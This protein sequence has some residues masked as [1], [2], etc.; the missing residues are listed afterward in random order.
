M[1]EQNE[2]IKRVMGIFAHPDDPEFFCGGTF[3]LWA[4]EGAEITFVLATSGDKGTSDPNLTPEMLAKIREK[5]ERY[6]AAVLG[7]HDVRFLRYRDGELEPSFDLKRDIVRVIR[8]VKPHIVVTNDPAVFYFAGR[9]VNHSDHR[10]IG[11]ATLDAVYPAARDR[12][13]FPE[14]IQGEGLAPHKVHE[15][16]MTRTNTPNIHIDVSDFIEMKIAALREHKSQ[17]ADMDAMAKRIRAYHEADSTEANPR[18]I[19]AFHKITFN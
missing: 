7:V 12:L 17:I 13:Y 11:G 9:G 5:E 16:Y 1:S 2:N 19:D 6:A 4:K 10:A 15:L 18:Y 3:A 14:L 8:T